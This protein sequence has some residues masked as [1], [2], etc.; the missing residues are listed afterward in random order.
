MHSQAAL[1]SPIKGHCLSSLRCLVKSLRFLGPNSNV[2]VIDFCVSIWHKTVGGSV[3]E[4]WAGAQIKILRK[5]EVAA[6]ELN[7]ARLDGEI[8][9]FRECTA[10]ILA[11]FEEPKLA[12]ALK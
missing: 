8:A 12:V 6:V 11:V 10:L 2:A 5:G 7:I 1:V 9:H 4:Y 3:L